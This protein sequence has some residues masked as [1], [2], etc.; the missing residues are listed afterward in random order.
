VDDVAAEWDRKAHDADRVRPPHPPEAAAAHDRWYLVRKM[1]LYLSST[2]GRKVL[3]AY[4]FVL[5]SDESDKIRGLRDVIA[6]MPPPE[7]LEP[8]DQWSHLGEAA[9]VRAA[10]LH[11]EAERA[12]GRP[13]P[14]QVLCTND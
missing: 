6:Q 3:E 11:R 14:V 8:S 1:C 12:A 7:T 5:G 2:K 10:V 9:S 4:E 13:E